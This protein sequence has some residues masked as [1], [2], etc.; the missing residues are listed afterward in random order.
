MINGI[1]TRYTHELN[2]GR[3]S[4][5][6]VGFQVRQTLKKT[7]GHIGRNVVNI[8]IKKILKNSLND[9]KNLFILSIHCR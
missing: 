4:K 8:T 7:G 2:K 3:G 6:R 9:K 1:R 5:F